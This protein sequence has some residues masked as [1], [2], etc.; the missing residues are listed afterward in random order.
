MEIMK[1]IEHKI[2]VL[3]K[4]AQKLNGASIKWAVGASLLLYLKGYVDQF[5]DIDLMVYEDD[6]LQAK[7]LLAEL[8]E[9]QRIQHNPYQSNHFYIFCVEDVEVDLMGRYIVTKDGVDHI[10]SLEKEDTVEFVPLHGQMIPLDSIVRWR[11]HYDVMGRQMKVE[12]IDRYNS[13]D[14]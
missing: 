2:E 13:Y 9:S 4:I 12:L 7:A 8:G 11:R 5:N 1:S 10:V 6:A 3:A 14:I